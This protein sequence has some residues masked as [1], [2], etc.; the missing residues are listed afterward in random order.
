MKEAFFEIFVKGI[1]VLTSYMNECLRPPVKTPA[2]NP[3]KSP[4][5]IQAKAPA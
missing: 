5:N 4:L 3:L 1:N 2:K